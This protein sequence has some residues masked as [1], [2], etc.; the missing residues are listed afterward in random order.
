MLHFVLYLATVVEQKHQFVIF[1][2]DLTRDFI[3][4]PP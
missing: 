2:L 1:Y 3:P 4:R